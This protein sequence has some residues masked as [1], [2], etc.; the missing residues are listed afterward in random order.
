MVSR[1]RPSVGRFAKRKSTVDGWAGK[2]ATTL[3]FANLPTDGFKIETNIRRTY[4]GGGNVTWRVSDPRGFQFEISSGNLDAILSCSTI[5]NGLI[6]GECVYARD[7]KDNALIPCHS[8]EYQ[9][10]LTDT[11]RVNNKVGLA[12][13]RRGDKVT[14]KNGQQFYFIGKFNMI[15]QIANVVEKDR[16]SYSYGVRRSY[17]DH[18]KYE[19][20]QMIRYV[21][22]PVDLAMTASSLEIVASPH[23]SYVN[24]R[25]SDAEAQGM[26][27]SFLNIIK[28]REL[29]SYRGGD[30]CYFIAV[31]SKPIDL[32]TITSKKT[33]LS[34]LEVDNILTCDLDVPFVKKHSS[35]KSFAAASVVLTTRVFL[36]HKS[37]GDISLIAKTPGYGYEHRVELA[38]VYESN[39]LYRI[40][41]E[42]QI[43]FDDFLKSKNMQ[44]SVPESPSFIMSTVC[45]DEANPLETINPSLVFMKK[46]LRDRTFSNVADAR[47]EVQD[48]ISAFYAALLAC[49]I[50]H[51]EVTINTDLMQKVSVNLLPK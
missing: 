4:F 11:A 34:K 5:E 7:G 9:E 44:S 22:K 10:C 26:Y 20:D 36:A 2:D 19:F 18:R 31:S 16:N 47:K 41:L 40:G 39:G 51:V 6:M 37:F 25:C 27:D 17:Y 21:F 29:S 30:H 48:Y 38:Y 14:L 12:S 8:P 15:A 1:L 13:L 46:N 23:V 32:D 43:T 42:T 33:L 45:R 3:E 24:G 28:R 35:T 49:D 50:Y